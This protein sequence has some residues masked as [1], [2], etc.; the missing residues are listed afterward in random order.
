MNEA[1]KGEAFSRVRLL[2]HELYHYYEYHRRYE[3]KSKSLC[4]YE[5][6][7]LRFRLRQVNNGNYR[8]HPSYFDNFRF[9]PIGYYTT[10]YLTILNISHMGM[11]T[12]PSTIGN[13]KSLK[14]LDIT[15]NRIESLPVE[16]W[17]LKSLEVF[18]LQVTRLICLSPGIGNLKHLK[19]LDL[20]FTNIRKIP[21][22]IGNLKYLSH[23]DLS[24]TYVSELP[25]DI[26]KLISLRYL[27]IRRCH[28]SNEY[29]NGIRNLLSTNCII[30][31]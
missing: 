5:S 11:V 15:Y 6:Q 24:Y 12:I 14:K 8:L 17:K 10:K 21:A 3:F 13:L 29:K 25:S 9:I 26:K 18:L 30:D 27:N 28:I 2:T 23:L 20:G 7:K 1:R 16:V 22:E 4:Y 19:H 31:K